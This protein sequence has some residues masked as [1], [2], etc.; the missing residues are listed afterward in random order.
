MDAHD[1]S[2]IFSEE[3]QSVASEWR[4]PAP[5][6]AVDDDDEVSRPLEHRPEAAGAARRTTRT[7][8]NGW[9][10]NHDVV[11]VALLVVSELVTNAVEHAQPPLAL[12]LQRD[13]AKRRVW[14]AVSDAGPAVQDGPWTT[15]CT[16]EE[17]GRG[18]GIVDSL[19][20][21]QGIQAHTPGTTHWALLSL[22]SPNA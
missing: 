19:A 13:E 2:T 16:P 14:V 6:R 20:D 5:R 1:R 18:L 17:H 3:T 15:S 22:D 10:A 12:H 4:I 8:L 7:V 21:A 9:R 11:E